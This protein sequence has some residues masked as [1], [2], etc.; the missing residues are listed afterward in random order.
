MRVGKQQSI[1]IAQRLKSASGD[2]AAVTRA[3]VE[4]VAQALNVS[5][6]VVEKVARDRKHGFDVSR[7]PVGEPGARV[8]AELQARAFD[9]KP[10]PL[11]IPSFVDV[12]SLQLF[13]GVA[14]GK[15]GDGAHQLGYQLILRDKDDTL[16]S[17]H[18]PPMLPDLSSTEPVAPPTV[19]FQRSSRAQGVSIGAATS[20]GQS[21]DARPL[22]AAAAKKLIPLLD[23]AVPATGDGTAAVI[24]RFF[25][26]RLSQLAGPADPKEE[27]AKGRLALEAYDAGHKEPAI[28]QLQ[29]LTAS[30][31]PRTRAS[32]SYFLGEV[33]HREQRYPEAIAALTTALKTDAPDLK[34][35]IHK[36]LA[37]VHRALRDFPTA[38][39]HAKLAV[40]H[41]GASSHPQ[42]DALLS[43][44]LFT[45]AVMQKNSGDLVGAVSNMASSLAH[46]QG[47]V[48][49]ILALA[50]YLALSGE[51]AAGDQ[52]LAQVPVPARGTLAYVDYGMNA[53]W[54]AALKG[55]KDQ[56]LSTMKATLEDAEKNKVKSFVVQYFS[57]EVD[58]DKYRGDPAFRALLAA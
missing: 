53:T 12:D 13:H 9:A 47:H 10:A 34:A 32:S 54:Y 16:V 5:P 55:D 35:I 11:K 30:S 36:E 23:R 42:K 43:Q 49:T 19:S 7:L 52:L 56:V 37:N 48:P 28:L 6:D 29:G 45:L 39:A 22:D 24:G 18:Q 51:K 1:D 33:L 38:I 46:N 14:L 3:E 2:G 15:Q 44:S 40:E 50:G 25:L 4:Q 21:G 17:L 26:D 58:L 20:A 27:G 31:D 57:S 41:F 8:R